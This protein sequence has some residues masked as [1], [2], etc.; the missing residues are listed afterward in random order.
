MTNTTRRAARSKGIGAG[1]HH[2]WGMATKSGDGWI[3][4]IQPYVEPRRPVALGRRSLSR[5]AGTLLHSRSTTPPQP[6]SS[7][8]EGEHVRDFT[9]AWDLSIK[10][11]ADLAGSLAPAASK[12]AA[13]NALVKALLDHKV[14]YLIPPD[15][16][17]VEAWGKRLLTVYAQTLRP[18]LR[19]ARRDQT[20]R[21]H[22]LSLLERARGAQAGTPHSSRNWPAETGPQAGRH[23]HRARV[24]IRAAASVARDVQ[25][26][27]AAV[28]RRAGPLGAQQPNL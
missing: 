9:H 13:I 17:S 11:V 1:I 8:F 28:D 27:P 16:L 25:D 18:V 23:E 10:R 2:Q 5:T 7:K 6:P 4:D 24:R 20:P 15:P 21:A 3:G 12:E 26:T 14:G 22:Q 19:A